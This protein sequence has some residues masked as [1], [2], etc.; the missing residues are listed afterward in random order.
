MMSFGQ[1]LTVCLQKKYVD[2]S[3]R[4]MRSEFWWFVLFNVLANLVGSMIHETAAII[5]TLLLLLPGIGVSV[6][7][8]HDVGRSG[9]W[10]LLSLLPVIGFLVLLYWQLQPS[11]PRTNAWGEPPVADPALSGPA[12]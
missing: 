3:G 5:I 7:R 8:L 9:W 6:R 4:A 12:V 11:E 2:F 10:L 1:A